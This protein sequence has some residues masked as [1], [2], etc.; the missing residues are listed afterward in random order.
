MA[1][2]IAEIRRRKVFQVTVAYAVVA[3]LLIQV[4]IAIKAP[5]QLPVWFDTAVIVLLLVGFPITVIFAWIYE[6][7]GGSLRRTPSADKVA[8][9]APT[10]SETSHQPVKPAAAASSLP[11]SI[12][13][14]PF[15]NMSPNP[16]HAYFAAGIHEEILNSLAN[17]KS[18]NVIARTSVL[19]YA[20]AQKPI[21]EIA[22]ALGV[23]T[24]MEGS[25][26]YA[27]HRVRVT[28]Q[29]IA[30]STGAHLWSEAYERE[31]DDIFAIQAD[32]ALR[33][34]NAMRAELTKEEQ[35]LVEAPATTSVA[36]YALYLQAMDLWS[37]PGSVAGRVHSL[38][39]Q[40][41]ELDPR[42]ALAL[43]AK[44]ASYA[45]QLVN[46]A[47]NVASDS[48]PLEP[49]IRKY[50]AAALAIDEHEGN[51]H[52]ALGTLA[53]FT[54]H[55]SDARPH[56]LRALERPRGG[57]L[58]ATATWG[59]AWAGEEDLAV[60]RAA[61]LRR[62][63]PADWAAHW[64]LGIVLNYARRYDEAVGALRHAVTMMPAVPLSHSWLALS[65]IARGDASSARQEIELT[66]TLL[67]EQRQIIYLLDLGYA[68][69]RVGD[70]KKAR[71]LF[72]EVHAL[73]E[74]QEIGAGG[75]ALSNMAIGRHDEALKWLRI[76]AEKAARH[77]ID[78]G[79]FSLMNLKRNFTAD[80]VLEQPEFVE[81][82]GRLK[83]D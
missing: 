52:T 25:V 3:W 28:A 66:E 62:L 41:I 6:F 70:V 65:E 16:D 60:E 54:W 47:G 64:S 14:L 50:A 23:E 68:Y 44:A 43:G 37:A 12:A 51:A 69:G 36:A 10:K 45:T 19:Q 57:I 58:M 20:G 8:Q 27:G 35:R 63:S 82:R 15:D 34:A 31:F 55:W 56:V 71:A 48:K 72:D 33:V 79:M 18:L 24:I 77:E 78:A 80:P 61:Y 13:V 17:L 46:T 73:A 4:V 81:V 21:R 49:L 2:F 74:R 38:L 5:L 29:L 53:G 42:F 32:I 59:L 39:D 1:S 76:G 9:N 30:A 22:D 67:G 40:A 11:N 83:G 75:R 26:R 7:S